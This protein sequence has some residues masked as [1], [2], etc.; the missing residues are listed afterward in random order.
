MTMIMIVVADCS[1]GVGVEAFVRATAITSTS[2]GQLWWAVD[3][4]GV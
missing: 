3:W 2:L 4:S 1:S